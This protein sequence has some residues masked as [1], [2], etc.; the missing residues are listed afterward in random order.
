[1]I[2]RSL[3]TVERILTP[4]YSAD[5]ASIRSAIV[6]PDPYFSS[7]VLLMHFNGTDGSTTFTDVK[8]HVLSVVGNSKIATAQSKFDGASGYFDGTGDYLSIADSSD[9]VFGSGDFTIEAFIKSSKS[10]FAIVDKYSGASTNWQLYVSSGKLQWYTDSAKKT[11]GININDNVWHHIAVTRLSGQ[12]LFFIDGVQDG[13][14]TT[15]NTNY[16]TTVTT[17]AIGAQVNNRNSN[18]DYQGYIDEL[19]ITKGVARYTANFTPPG[20]AFPDF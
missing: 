11:G 7:V 14:P 2:R 8:G 16:S 10:T 19:R 15:D 18:Y 6:G 9:F 17:F 1:M 3:L 12:M 4:H 13:T 5:A 20:A